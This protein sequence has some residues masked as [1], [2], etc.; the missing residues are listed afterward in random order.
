MTPQEWKE[1]VEK[2]A[3]GWQNK[4]CV[5]GLLA[6][7][8]ARTRWAKLDFLKGVQFVLDN[9]IH[10][11]QVS[12]VA[13]ASEHILN[14]SIRGADVSTLSGKTLESSKMVIDIESLAKLNQALSKLRGGK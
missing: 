11:P 8:N 6:F 12:E 13:K 10:V 9:L 3:D 7:E 14:T 1:Y 2:E 4:D 5:E